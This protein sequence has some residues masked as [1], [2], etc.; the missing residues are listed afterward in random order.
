MAHTTLA[1]SHMDSLMEMEDI[2]SAKGAIMKAKSGIML[3]KEKG[4]WLTIL[5]IILIQDNGSMICQTDKAKRF[6]KMELHI[7]EIF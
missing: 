7:R 5:K 2:S 4:H 1:P 3:Q 6:G